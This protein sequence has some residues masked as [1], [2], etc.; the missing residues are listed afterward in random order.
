MERSRA[1][2]E[3]ELGWAEKGKRRGEGRKGLEWVL[4]LKLLEPLFF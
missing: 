3:E 4:R 2:R 1:E